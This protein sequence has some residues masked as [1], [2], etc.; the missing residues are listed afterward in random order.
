MR[1]SLEESKATKSIY[2]CG[3]NMCFPGQSGVK[4]EAKEFT[5]R[6]VIKRG[7]VQEE[8]GRARSTGVGE[9]NTVRFRRRE[10]ETMIGSPR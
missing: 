10:T 9:E 7:V 5:R 2:F 8:W 1:E 4:S 6:A 3:K